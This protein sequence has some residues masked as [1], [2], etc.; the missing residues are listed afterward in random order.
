[1]TLPQWT[2]ARLCSVTRS[3]SWK[4]YARLSQCSR[5]PRYMYDGDYD[6]RDIV[7]PNSAGHGNTTDTVM[8]TG[9]CDKGK[10]AIRAGHCPMASSSSMATNR[11]RV[12]EPAGPVRAGP[13]VPNVSQVE[14]SVV[15]LRGFR[16][17]PVCRQDRGASFRASLRR[18]HRPTEIIVLDHVLPGGK[19]Q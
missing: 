17:P 4:G 14:H 19:S 7:T 6:G 18:T 13:L 12:S 3:S 1:M 8:A 15:H 5:L 11:M 16:A 10:F 2:N 9:W